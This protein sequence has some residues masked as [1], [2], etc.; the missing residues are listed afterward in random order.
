MESIPETTEEGFCREILESSVTTLAEELSSRERR[1]AGDSIH[2]TR[3]ASRRMRAVL[4]AF[5]DLFP[6]RPWRSLYDRVREVTVDLGKVRESEVNLALLKDLTASGDMAENICREYMQERFQARLRKRLRRLKK[7]LR[8]LD[9]DR[10]HAQANFLLAGLGTGDGQAGETG[11]TEPAS[12]SRPRLAAIAQKQ[13]IQPTLFELRPTA[14]AR[15]SRILTEL[16][17]PIVQFRPRYDFRNATDERLHELRIAAKKIRYAMEIFDPLWPGGLK[18]EIAL[19]RALQDA[20]GTYHDWCILRARIQ[21]EI[22]RLTEQETTH[23]AFQM[24]RLLAQVDDSRLVLRKKLAP[25]ITRLRTALQQLLPD[26]APAVPRKK[27]VRVVAE[28]RT[29][30][31]VRGQG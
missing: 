1:A 18:K 16:S 6:P 29:S 24:G 28:A 17:V 10:I 22:R 12:K 25:S 7:K 31:A 3:V 30:Q 14:R 13:L 5:K 11:G 26:A 21:A 23:L 2:D 9:G 15:G 20:G 27:R 8:K 4:E 19:A